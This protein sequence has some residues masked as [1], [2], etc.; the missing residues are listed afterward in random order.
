MPLMAM[1]SPVWVGAADGAARCCAGPRTFQQIGI[2]QGLDVFLSAE[3][4]FARAK[5]SLYVL[6][7]LSLKQAPEQ[8][9]FPGF[10]PPPMD[11]LFFAVFPDAPAVARAGAIARQLRDRHGLRGRPITPSH[12]HVSLHGIGQYPGIP[13]GVVAK[14]RAAAA[15]VSAAAFCIGFD[16]AGSF[17]IKRRL[18]P[19]VLRAEAP[20]APLFGL[21][22]RLGDA[23][24][25]HGLRTEAPLSFTP[26]MTLLYDLRHI[27][28]CAV[29]P[30]TWVVRELVLVHSRHGETRHIWLGR[31]PLRGAPAG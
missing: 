4:A 9:C 1:G 5:C 16:H 24:A 27:E 31:W 7:M 12:L 10:H 11:R 13:N 25:R 2:R 22:L 3:T 18:L 8:L 29:E 30:V 17:A 23:M 21:R 6:I 15:T 19:L 14:A 26:H 28:T 20:P